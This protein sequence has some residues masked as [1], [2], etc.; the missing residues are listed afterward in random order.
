MKTNPMAEVEE[1][2]EK[3]PFEDLLDELNEL[4]GL[5]LLIG[6]DGKPKAIQIELLKKYEDL[7]EDFFDTALSRVRLKE[8]DFIP[9]DHAVAEIKAERKV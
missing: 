2:V 9:F 7:L 5:T 1:K 6:K 8:G 3:L 4:E